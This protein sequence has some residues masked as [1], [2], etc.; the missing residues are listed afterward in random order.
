ME[1]DSQGEGVGG[2]SLW[3]EREAVGNE[4]NGRGQLMGG[5]RGRQK[6]E[7]RQKEGVAEEPD[8]SD[9]AALLLGANL[10]LDEQLDE[11]KRMN[12]MMLFSKCMAERYADRPLATCRM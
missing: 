8:G 5:V 11:V 6:E 9:K 3:K 10:K 1:T 12:Q 7:C 4:R 2:G